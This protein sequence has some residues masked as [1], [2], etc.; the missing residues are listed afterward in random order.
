M[1]G[2]ITTVILAICLALNGIMLG[3]L[4]NEMT[5]DKQLKAAKYQLELCRENLDSGSC[6]IEV[7]RYNEEAVNEGLTDTVV[8]TKSEKG[9]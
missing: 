6:E 2:K 8:L 9:V 5:Y 1:E 7:Y 4:L 3:F